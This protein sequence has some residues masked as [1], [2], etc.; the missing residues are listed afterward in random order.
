MLKG[1]VVAWFPRTFT[2]ILDRRGPLVL[3][4]G[5]RPPAPRPH[6]HSGKAL[7]LE[8]QPSR[9]L[10][11]RPRIPEAMYADAQLNRWFRLGQ[12]GPWLKAMET[13]D[14]DAHGSPGIDWYDITSGDE[15]R[16]TDT[17]DIMANLPAFL[18]TLDGVLAR[19]AHL[20]NLPHH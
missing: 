10:R 9:Q 8:F 4:L 19:S 3:V 13:L 20:R 2:S 16:S 1:A 7:S 5:D 18:T 12:L 6:K 17:A 15:G 14:S 11:A